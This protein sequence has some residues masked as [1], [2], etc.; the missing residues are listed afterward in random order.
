MVLF[1][2]V[3]VNFFNWNV[4]ILVTELV[5]DVLTLSSVMHHSHMQIKEER[6]ILKLQSYALSLS[7]IVKKM[8][9]L[10]F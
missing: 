2:L 4:E 10:M 6:E 1:K 7:L 3:M 9:P 8:L 5:I